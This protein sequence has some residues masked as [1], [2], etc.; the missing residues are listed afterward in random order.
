MR[1]LLF[2]YCFF[3]YCSIV[4]GQQNQLVSPSWIHTF[5]DHLFTGRDELADL[6]RDGEGNIFGFLRTE[7]DST[8]SDVALLKLNAAGILQWEYRFSSGLNND[9]DL[10]LFMEFAD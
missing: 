9:Y 3:C 8:A 6:K 7:R 2:S 4:Y 10:P 1:L 5:G